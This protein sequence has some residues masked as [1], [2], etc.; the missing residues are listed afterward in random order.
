M[1]AEIFHGGKED[2]WLVDFL[3]TSFYEPCTHG[4]CYK[5]GASTIYCTVC[6]GSPF[7]LSCKGRHENN[8]KD[9]KLLEVVK[10]SHY[11]AVKYK[12]IKEILQVEGIRINIINSNQILFLRCRQTKKDTGS[13]KGHCK[14]CNWPLDNKGSYC[15]IE[16]ML[17]EKSPHLQVELAECNNPSTSFS[18]AKLTY[19]GTSQRR[20]LERGKST[21]QSVL[22]ASEGT[23]Q[24]RKLERGKSTMQ[25]SEVPVKLLHGGSQPLEIEPACPSKEVAGSSEIEAIHKKDALNYRTRN[26]KGAPCRSPLF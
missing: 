23:S 13:R 9:H 17:L 7:C 16:C 15:S 19:Q 12:D 1:G 20:K 6:M 4:G 22:E 25:A 26:R 21:M 10:A 8:F 18:S 2:T 5:G 24:R 14:R 3:R 11:V